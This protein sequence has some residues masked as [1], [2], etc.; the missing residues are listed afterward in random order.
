[1]LL[2]FRKVT[3]GF[4][5][6][7]IFGL[8][9][10]ATVLFLIPHNGLQ[11]PFA[12][13]VAK[14]GG[15]Q[16]TPAELNRELDIAL[17]RQRA[18]GHNFTREEAIQQGAPQQLLDALIS[19]AALNNY[20][21]RNGVNASDAQV[22]AQ[23]RQYPVTDPATHR[24]DQARYQAFLADLNYTGPEFERVIR[25]DLTSSMIMESL[26]AGV[27][28][29]SSFGAIGV[30]IASENRTVTVA[31]APISLAGNVAPPTAAQ[32][33]TFYDQIKDRLQL[34]E[35]RQV[36]LVL[37]R[38]ADFTQR[39]NVTDQQVQDEFDRRA[40]SLGTPEKRSSVRIVAQSQA[41]AND[42]ASRINAGQAPDAV[43]QALHLQVIHGTDEARAA[44][45]D[46]PVAAAVFSQAP[47]APARAVQGQLSWVVVKTLSVTPGVT[48]Q[49]SAY[50]DQ[51]RTELQTV[52]SGDLID[53]AISNFEEAR[54]GGSTVAQAA[55]SAGLATVS[56]PAVE[57]QGH[58]THG[59]PVPVLSGSPELLRAAFQ[60]AEGEASDFMQVTDGEALVAVDHVTP[61]HARPLAEI[62]DD[63]AH[64]WVAR[65]INRR[66]T[67][68]ADQV[69]QA[70]QH[71]QSFAQAAR[72]HNMQ[73]VLTSTPIDRQG[74]ARIP[75]QRLG[76][77]IFGAQPN[78]VV[79]DECVQRPQQPIS[80]LCAHGDEFL[81][82]QVERINRVD[83][84][85]VPQ[86][87]ERM[88]T[89]V[90]QE[91]A[92]SFGEA[93]EA[94]ITADAKPEKNTALMTRL[95]PPSGAA[96]EGGDQGQ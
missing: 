60:T 89:Q 12:Q 45:T 88:R 6:T 18:Q 17:R 21:E 61:P 14:V 2:Q 57:A 11:N 95:F 92:Q 49:F 82:A 28:A 51:I 96:A 13:Y 35:F 20:A 69:A 78:A 3:R 74:V 73:I 5:A 38:K 31:Q 36:T 93:I 23:I 42:V 29:P 7:I 9:G 91:L 46:A 59:Q 55:Q 67:E 63:L 86:L 44:V 71:G 40:P 52:A 41:Q 50:K 90:Q 47:N 75:A 48:P 19:R 25:A 85:T 62:H 10:V 70:V 4:V 15:A 30:A 27:R 58:D 87:V 65:E 68:M 54:A 39:A 32:L 77:Q 16:I 79:S 80:G 76:S 34:P 83:P 8:I 24:F 43:A 33:Q 37:A 53:T 64:L 81:I 56:V 1:M 84:A 72:A 66:M 22:A 94:Q 26:A